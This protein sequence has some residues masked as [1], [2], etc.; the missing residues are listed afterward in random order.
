ME[1]P[2]K[3]VSHMAQAFNPLNGRDAVR[4]LHKMQ[5]EIS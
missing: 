2:A 3:G 4:A 5:R 1:N